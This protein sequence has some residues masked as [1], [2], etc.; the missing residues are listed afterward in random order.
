[1]SNLV[2]KLQSS[3]EVA[4]G[5]LCIFYIIFSDEFFLPLYSVSSLDL[6]VQFQWHIVVHRSVLTFL[7]VSFNIITP[8]FLNIFLLHRKST[9]VRLL[10]RF[11]D[12]DDGRILISGKDI[13]DIKLDSLRRSLGIVP[14]VFASKRHLLCFM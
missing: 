8:S 10:Y 1:M 5:M 9:I 7:Q 2:K 13:K 3:E 6:H 14:Q 11:Y 12:P 4:Q